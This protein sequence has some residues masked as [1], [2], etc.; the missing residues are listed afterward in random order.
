MTKEEF[1]VYK[2]ETIE[3]LR[4]YREIIEK[5]TDAMWLYLQILQDDHRDVYQEW[6]ESEGYPSLPKGA[7]YFLDRVDK[8]LLCVISHLGET[9]EWR[10]PCAK[11]HLDDLLYLVEED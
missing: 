3:K 2:E 6:Q 11:Q 1:E 5:H 8:E 9:G 10:V 4:D 7:G